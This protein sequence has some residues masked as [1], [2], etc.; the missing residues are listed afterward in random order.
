MF[1]NKFVYDL[2]DFLLQDSS[3][4]DFE[5]EF[6]DKKKVKKVFVAS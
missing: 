6:A 5:E 1:G 4:D 3:D 2:Y